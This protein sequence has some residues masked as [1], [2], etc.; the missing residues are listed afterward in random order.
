MVTGLDV[1][2]E[3]FDAYRDH[4]VLIGGTASSLVMDELGVDFRVGHNR[5]GVGFSI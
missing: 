2:K 5:V 4:Y 3:H 1:F